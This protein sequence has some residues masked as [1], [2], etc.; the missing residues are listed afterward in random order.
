MPEQDSMLSAI[1]PKSDN[2][3]P[4]FQWTLK[5]TSVDYKY[6]QIDVALS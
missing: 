6:I 1:D 3:Q 4:K 5:S 2:F